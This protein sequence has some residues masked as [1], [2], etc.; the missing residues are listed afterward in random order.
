MLAWGPSAP[1][2]DEESRAR[3]AARASA[4]QS[5][6][7]V[8]DEPAATW[9][10]RSPSPGMTPRSVALSSSSS[11]SPSPGSRSTGSRLRMR[12]LQMLNRGRLEEPRGGAPKT[13][14]LH[15]LEAGVSILL[16]MKAMASVKARM[17]S[18]PASGGPPPAIKDNR[19]V[20]STW[21]TR[22][23]VSMELSGTPGGRSPV[24]LSPMGG[25]SGA[26]TGM[27]W[28]SSQ[29]AA[30]ATP[31]CQATLSP[32]GSRK[33]LL[34]SQSGSLSAPAGTCTAMPV[35]SHMRSPDQREL[36]LPTRR[37]ARGEGRPGRPTLSTCGRQL[38][39]M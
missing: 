11:C 8:L 29:R 15:S 16:E 17:S 2:T 23:S 18:N 34:G 3:W 25:S 22:G 26:M 27:A 33:S 12:R 37:C 28:G 4:L 9:G 1:I 24:G 36:A 20:R 13:S 5:P 32:A 38:L 7:C 19:E 21:A 35:D 6:A 39:A 10:S 31:G 14:S 30:S